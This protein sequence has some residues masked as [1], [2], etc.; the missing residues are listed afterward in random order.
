M[1][2]NA[3]QQTAFNAEWQRLAAFQDM[4]PFPDENATNRD[5]SML[6]CGL[7]RGYELLENEDA[8]TQ[9]PSK[10]HAHSQSYH[11]K[12]ATVTEQN[13][14]EIKLPNISSFALAAQE[15]IKEPFFKAADA[16]L[17][18]TDTDELNSNRIKKHFNKI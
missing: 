18:I 4:E 11:N 17:L 9:T 1:S 13:D 6:A 10:K 8:P 14:P 15:I 2:S 5:T 12:I 3:T 7:I 16:I